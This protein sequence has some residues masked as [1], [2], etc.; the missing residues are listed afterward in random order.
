MIVDVG[1]P[2]GL[3]SLG[4]ELVVSARGADRSA[5]LGAIARLAS[6]H[7]AHSVVRGPTNLATPAFNTHLRHQRRLLRR[8]HRTLLHRHSHWHMRRQRQRHHHPRMHLTKPSK[9]DKPKQIY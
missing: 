3:G 5:A 9:W 1:Q 2:V 7:R 6:V 4:I 8:L